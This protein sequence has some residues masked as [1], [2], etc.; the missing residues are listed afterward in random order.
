MLKFHTGVWVLLCAPVS[1]RF[2]GLFSTYTRTY[3]SRLRHHLAFF[4][5]DALRMVKSNTEHTS[6]VLC[7]ILF[8]CTVPIVLCPASFTSCFSFLRSC[9]ICSFRFSF[10]PFSAACGSRISSC[11]SNPI[12]DC[13]FFFESCSS[14]MRRCFSITTLLLTSFTCMKLDA[15]VLQS[16]QESL[17]A[18]VHPA[19]S[20]KVK[21]LP[22]QAKSKKAMMQQSSMN[23]MR[24]KGEMFST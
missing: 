20:L 22:R 23:Y 21:R 17:S 13:S 7:C 18:S 4:R 3:G 2:P 9:S 19:A 14:S 1:R 6:A 16:V 12:V 15:L 24:P 5:F 8:F 10:F 11:S